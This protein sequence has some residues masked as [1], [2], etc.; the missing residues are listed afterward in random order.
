M[1]FMCFMFQ[2]S[3]YRQAHTVNLVIERPDTRRL[4]ARLREGDTTTE[5]IGWQPEQSAAGLL[6]AGETTVRGAE[7]VTISYSSFWN[8]LDRAAL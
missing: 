2:C 4:I 8:D 1:S 7:A 6:A 5:V 3:S